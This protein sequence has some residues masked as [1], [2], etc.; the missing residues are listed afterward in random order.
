[1]ASPGPFPFVLTM[2]NSRYRVGFAI[3]SCSIRSLY[4]AKF[5]YA[6]RRLA[7]IMALLQNHRITVH[8]TGMSRC[9]TMHVGLPDFVD[10]RE[11][12]PSARQEGPAAL[13]IRLT[14]TDDS[15]GANC[16]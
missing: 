4:G 14:L 2:M 13:P 10:L 16:P 9:G 15:D 12:A 1:M 5:A 8:H 7:Q 11:A 3:A 6:K